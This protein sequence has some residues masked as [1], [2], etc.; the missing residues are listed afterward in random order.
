MPSSSG[1]AD[2]VVLGAVVASTF[3][4]IVGWNWDI[5]WHRS[6][7][8]DQ[9]FTWPH[10]SIYLA[11]AIAF[12]YNAWLVLRGTFGVARDE[13]GIRV[14]GFHG[15]AGAFVTLWAVLMQAT[16]IVFDD[17]WHN[18]FGLD[19]AVFSPPHFMLAGA[20]AVFYFGQFMLAA[21][22]RNR[23]L[24]GGERAT[25]WLLLVVWSFFLGHLLIGMDPQ[26]GPL[27][28][29]SQSFLISCALILPFSLLLI[30][31]VMDSR[32]AATV[33]AAL[34]MVAIVVLM[35]VI[36]L[37]PAK[38][39]FGPVFH[40]ITHFLPPS[41]PLVLVVPALATSLTAWALRGRARAL[42][43]GASGLAF[44]VAFLATNAAMGALLVS[45]LGANRFFMGDNPGTAF[46][47]RYLPI[48]MLGFNA[49]SVV[50][51]AAAVVIASVSCSLG[52]ATGR[53]LRTVVR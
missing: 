32:W 28:I 20:I 48:F 2:R 17:W 43:Y 46:A 18:T 5:S 29:L 47:P 1:T 22:L 35:Q 21:S 40:R 53:W 36:Q 23:G 12:A 42:V 50:W 7:G 4:M 14:L 27:A 19:N 25:R 3:C 38:P 37:F 44:V 30:D 26:Y 24:G 34:Y 15:P 8:R 39:L 51:V 33:S 10:V 52:A 16:A 41:F 31:A 11:L 6:I 13:P 45:P 9:V 49:A